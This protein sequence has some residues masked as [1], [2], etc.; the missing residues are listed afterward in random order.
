VG[1]RNPLS[2]Q[3]DWRFSPR[4]PTNK[5]SLI[6]WSGSSFTIL[7]GVAMPLSLER[8]LADEPGR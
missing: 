7:R 2:H 3:L 5:R 6:I 4:N 1:A 8:E